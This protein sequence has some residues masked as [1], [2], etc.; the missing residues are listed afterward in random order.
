[1]PLHCTQS[2]PRCGRRVEV[3]VPMLG[4][5]VACR[6]CQAEFIAGSDEQSDQPCQ[7][8]DDLLARVEAVLKQTGP[9]TPPRPTI[10]S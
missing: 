10:I 9:E 1:M 4:C 7:P 5:Q 8:V 6:H 3:P 2:C